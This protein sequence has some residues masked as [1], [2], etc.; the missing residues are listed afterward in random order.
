MRIKPSKAKVEHSVGK[1]DY[2]ASKTEHISGKLVNSIIE[3]CSLIVVG[4][5][6][7]Y[8]RILLVIRSKY[9][10]DRF[11][12]AKA[13]GEFNRHIIDAVCDLVPAIKPQSAFYEAIGW[14]GI[15]GLEEAIAYAK[16]K[17]LIVILDSIRMGWE[18]SSVL[19]AASYMPTARR[20]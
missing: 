16:A 17:G 3:K 2:V 20:T 14:Q 12:A 9:E 18:L 6:P 1:T 4:L 19:H 7:V 5:D 11:G 10:Q 15:G 13:I 8:E